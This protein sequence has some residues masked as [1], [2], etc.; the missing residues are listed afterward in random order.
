M[1]WRSSVWEL[2]RPETFSVPYFDGNR[3]RMP[4]VLLRHKATGLTAYFANVHNPADTR[5]YHGQQ[6]WRD[7]ATAVEVALVNRLAAT[8]IPVFLTGDMNER[9]SYFCALTAGT[10]M[11]AARGGSNGAGGCDAQNPRAVDWVF[12][13]PASVLRPTTRT[14]AR[15]WTGPPTT[16][17]SRPARASTRAPS[18]PPR[19]A[20]Q[21]AARGRVAGM[22]SAADAAAL[23]RQLEEHGVGFW[24]IGGWGVDA[25][26]HR[27][28]RPHKDLDVLVRLADLPALRRLLDEARVHPHAGVGGEPLG[29]GAGRSVA[30]GV[31]RDRPRGPRASTCTWSTYGRTGGSSSCTTPRGRSRLPRRDRH[32]R[33]DGGAVRV[34][35]GPAGAAH[36]LRAARRAPAGPGAA[37]RPRLRPGS[38]VG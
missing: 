19:P 18:P 21:P 26:L 13:S 2:V 35:A 9:D 23:C 8:G 3:R 11:V 15:S 28:T 24:L 22:L 33:R 16:R 32:D 31:R 10:S 12:G 7:Q 6:R 29:R 34:G 4:V 36:R 17:W 14:A 25:L 30:D 20:D 27:Q 38:E 37:P 1:A 5:R